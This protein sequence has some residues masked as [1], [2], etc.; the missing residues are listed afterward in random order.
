MP[1]CHQRVEQ[2]A[3]RGLIGVGGDFPRAS[4]ARRD[5][6][7]DAKLAA[8]DQRGAAPRSIVEFMEELQRR[9]NLRT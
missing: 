1:H 2:A 6:I 4:L 5:P 8:G 7:K 3:H 9:R